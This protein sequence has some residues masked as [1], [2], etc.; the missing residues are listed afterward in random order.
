M[1]QYVPEIYETAR[2]INNDQNVS[3]T[4]EYECELTTAN[5]DDVST[6]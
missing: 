5:I 1:T 2:S 6:F 4:D 3:I